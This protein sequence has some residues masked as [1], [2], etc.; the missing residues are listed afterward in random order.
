MDKKIAFISY[1][2]HSSH[3]NYGAALHGYA[4]QKFLQ[5][6]NIDS[7]MIDYYPQDLDGYSIKYPVFNNMRF[8]RVREFR[9]S[10]LNWGLGFFS[11]LKKYRKFELFFKK[12]I[13][14]TNRLYKHSKLISPKSYELFSFTHFICESDVI[15]KLYKKNV[16]NEDFFL[17][18]PA[19][20]GKKKIAYAP[21]LGSR[22][23]DN[24]EVNRLKFLTKDFFALSTRERVSAEYL[25]KI[26]ERKVDWVL[27]PVFFLDKEDYRKIA[28]K[29]KEKNYLLV[30]NCMVND[31]VM[32]SQAEELAQ[33]MGLEMIEISNF[34]VN[35]IRYRHKVLVD[36]GIEEW[37]G[38]FLHADFVVCNAFHGFCFSMIFEKECFVFQRD[39]SDFRMQNITE[40]LGLSNRLVSHEK[41][42]IPEKYEKIDFQ[43]VRNIISLLKEKSSNYLLGSLQE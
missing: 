34:F 36:V 40:A 23:F 26:L 4:F 21:S 8:W 35:K 27:D 28:T 5:K 15:W 29:P 18:F 3:M 17:N 42:V 2:L 1:A 13:K 25:S 6:R 16:F 32:L 22:P 39:A 37:L 20:Q 7:T 43:S 9:R 41:K 11:N 30:Y 38:F 12:N 24:E 14:K 31:L 19:A 33:K 10:V